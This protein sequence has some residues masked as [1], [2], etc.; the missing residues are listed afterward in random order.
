MLFPLAWQLLFA[1]PVTFMSVGVM[2][3]SSKVPLA[4][5]VLNAA[6]QK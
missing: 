1:L 5:P 3:T 2:P 6:S 4:G